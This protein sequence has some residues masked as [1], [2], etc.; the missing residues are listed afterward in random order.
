MDLSSQSS[1]V[2]SQCARSDERQLP[3]RRLQIAKKP[4]PTRGA[5][6]E[7]VFSC[8]P[9][10]TPLVCDGV[11][12]CERCL[13]PRFWILLS[14]RVSREQQSLDLCTADSFQT[15]LG[16]SP[17]TCFSIPTVPIPRY[18]AW[19]YT[20]QPQRAEAFRL[21]ISQPA[22]ACLWQTF[23]GP[24]GGRWLELLNDGRLWMKVMS[25]APLHG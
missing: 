10:L 15:Y 17:C 7:A 14:F 21:H 11:L 24:I 13:Q 4:A 25:A 20:R 19:F 23:A 1:R 16:I 12:A 22:C 9:A 8:T 18:Q 6:S 5:T 2:G 3:G